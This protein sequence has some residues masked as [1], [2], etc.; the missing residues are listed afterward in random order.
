MELINDIRASDYIKS[1][2]TISSNKNIKSNKKYYIFAINSL[3]DNAQN[4]TITFDSI[5]L[6]GQGS[7]NNLIQN[8]NLV[9]NDCLIDKISILDK[10][11]LTNTITATNTTYTYGTISSTR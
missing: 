6:R 5:N 8:A 4:T 9:F 3:L 2:I 7:A 1:D 11:N 10:D